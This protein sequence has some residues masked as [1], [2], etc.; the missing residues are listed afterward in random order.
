[1]GSYRESHPWITFK[2]GNLNELG[3]LTWLRLG[4]A[5]AICKAL[6]GTPLPPDLAEGFYGLALDKGA[7]ATT[8]IEGNRL[9]E[10]Q[11]AGIR[12][13]TYEAPPSQ[14]Y[15]QIEVENVINAFAYIDV[16]LIEEDPTPEITRE[17]ICNLNLMLLSG[18]EHDADAVPGQVRDHSVVVA[19]YRGAPPRD[20]EYLLDQLACW[21]ESPDFRSDNPEVA[22][23]F[24]VLCAIYAHLYIAW[25]HPFGDGNGRTAR[26]LE[27]LIL[28]RSGA[29]PLLAAHLLSN[30]YN[31]TRDRYY[32]EL[33]IASRSQD[34]HGFVRYAVEG[35]VVELR[36][37]LAQVHEAHFDR[38]WRDF[39]NEVLDRRAATKARER[40]RT[41]VLTMPKDRALRIDELQTELDNELA[42]QYLERAPITIVRDLKALE[43]CGLVRRSGSEWGTNKDVLRAYS[44]PVAG[45][46]S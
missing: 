16:L 33:S 18:T 32:R 14:E 17:Q 7:H 28:A 25:I 46:D 22:F 45:G 21:L 10:P 30:H 2:V 12:A 41:L 4:E 42:R 39:V 38:L 34:A 43:A 24:T 5:N 11:V 3:A 6:I 15:Q 1:M 40:Q 31:E 9:T 23:A 35:F 37:Q 36:G 8:A 19:D 26:L 29:V 13:G 27:F 44:P 20:C